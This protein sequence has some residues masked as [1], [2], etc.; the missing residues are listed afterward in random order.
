MSDYKTPKDKLIS[1]EKALALNA[2]FKAKQKSVLSA[3]ND[4][5]FS[6]SCWY[7]LEDLEGYINYVKEQALAQKISVDGIRFYF[8][9]YPDNTEDKT[10]A[11]Q[12]TLFM[13]PTKA[14][15]TLTSRDGESTTNNGDS[16][17]VT[18]ISAMNYGSTGNPPRNDYGEQ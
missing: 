9:V 6:C 14:N 13:C 7:S 10:K 15:T 16:E 3:E 5:N 8:G 2:N 11:G 17:D 18:T 12:N 4:N 1:S